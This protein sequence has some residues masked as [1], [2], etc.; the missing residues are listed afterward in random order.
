M[1]ERALG[2]KLYLL[3]L[4]A[5]FLILS[6]LPL[7][8]YNRFLPPE[9]DSVKLSCQLASLDLLTFKAVEARIT[10]PHPTRDGEWE[11]PLQLS[12]PSALLRRHVNCHYAATPHHQLVYVYN[13]LLPNVSGLVNLEA[14]LVEERA[15]YEQPWHAWNYA[16]GALRGFREYTFDEH[17]LCGRAIDRDEDWLLVYLITKTGLFAL[18]V[19]LAGL[20]LLAK[21]WLSRCYHRLH[22]QHY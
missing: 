16:G 19:P 8:D 17:G 18:A 14:L 22:A 4:V 3:T 11:S 1:E 5:L 20:L 21:R 7:F 12:L 9:P 13:R 10:L 15:R 2:I 6:W